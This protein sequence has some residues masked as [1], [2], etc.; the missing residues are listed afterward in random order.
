MIVAKRIYLSATLSSLTSASTNSPDIALRFQL[1]TDVSGCVTAPFSFDLS[2]VD[3]IVEPGDTAKFLVCV[4]PTMS[5]PDTCETRSN[6]TIPAVRFE[7]PTQML[8]SAEVW[9]VSGERIR[10]LARERA[11]KTISG[12]LTGIPCHHSLPFLILSHRSR[13]FPKTSTSVFDR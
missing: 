1:S 6:R 12:K 13:L 2:M 3:F 5:G 7:L 10:V 11:G 9:S 4:N 8:V